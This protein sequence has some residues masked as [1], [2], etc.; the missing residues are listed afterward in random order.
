MN[1]IGFNIIRLL[2]GSLTWHSY[3]LVTLGTC[4]LHLILHLLRLILIT[5]PTRLLTACPLPVLMLHATCDAYLIHID[6]I[7]G[8]ELQ[9]PNYCSTCL[10]YCHRSYLTCYLEY[11]HGSCLVYYPNTVVVIDKNMYPVLTYY[12]IPDLACLYPDMMGYL[13]TKRRINAHTIRG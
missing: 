11:Y 5:L 2:C 6:M 7:H 10:A 12:Y 8:N 3:S 4:L 1:I 9:Y 13:R